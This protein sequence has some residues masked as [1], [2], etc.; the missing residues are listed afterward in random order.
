MKRFLVKVICF[1][2][3]LSLLGVALDFL[4]CKGLLKMDD[5]RFQDY[6]AILK[7]GMENDILI[8]GNSRGKS[9][10]NPHIIDSLSHKSSFSIGIGGYPINAQVM[11]YHLYRE[12][13][14]KPRL[15]IQN[16]DYMTVNTIEDIR[17]Q[18]QSEQFFPLVYD[19]KSRKELKELGYGFFELNVP[20]YRF[21]GYQQVIKNGLLEIFGLKHYV[22]RPAY[23]G[24][25][26]EEG[27]WDGTELAA[28]DR[29]YA[30]M[31]EQGK[32]TL[33][34]YL[35]SCHADSI[36]VVLVNSPMYLGVKDKL[37]G[38]DDAR[39]YFEQLAAKYGYL[40]LDFVDDFPISQ[41]TSNFCVSVHM[42]PVATDEFTRV[43]CDSLFRLNIL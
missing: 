20:L 27:T 2:V 24:F 10:F 7:G 28:M 13:N 25:R 23:K 11:K 21:F 9:H 29:Q 34:S 8:M 35:S 37:S 14:R 12:H 6:A 41:D 15:I 17:H 40:Y 22:S 42:N 33:E 43:L 16:V 19:R 38:L 18:H 4:L 1:S 39:A 30:E 31:S 5:Y 32:E 26:A 36:D 3:V